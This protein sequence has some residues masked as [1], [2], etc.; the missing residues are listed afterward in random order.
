[1]NRGAALAV[2]KEAGVQHV[3]A[4]PETGRWMC[5]CGTRLNGL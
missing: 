2:Y 1:M 5:I 4:A 3:M